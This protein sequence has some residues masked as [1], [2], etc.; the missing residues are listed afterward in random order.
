M[1]KISPVQCL[2]YAT[3]Y[4]E[5]L[6][7]VSSD[8]GVVDH[9]LFHAALDEDQPGLADAV[10]EILYSPEDKQSVLALEDDAAQSVLDIIQHAVD[11]ELLRT[12]DAN[13]RAC[14][15]VGKL[16]KA[17]DKVPSSILIYGVTQREEHASFCGGFGDVF[18][19]MY[20]GS[21][22]ALKHMRMFQE[23]D[24]RHIRRKFAREAMVWQRLRDPY[25]VPLIGIDT[26]SFPSSLCL[27]SPWMAHGTV[28]KYL[29]GI[30]RAD[31]QRT[32]D[33]LIHEIAQGLAFLHN[34]KVVHGDLRGSNI[35]V[36]DVGRAC[37][38]DFGLTILTDATVT[39][40]PNAAGSV[41]WMAPETLDPRAW[42]LTDARRTPASDIYAFGCVCLEL[43]TGLPPFHRENFLDAPVMLQVLR[44]ERPSRPAG[45]VIPDHIWKIMQ[46]CWAHNIPDRPTILGIVLQLTRRR[47]VIE[48]AERGLR[49][50]RT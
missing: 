50:Q 49:Q 8:L 20:R 41:R 43:Y 34:Q 28:L 19:A 45:E 31:R 14:R 38:T 7:A 33:R 16:A 46:Q 35:L 9:H 11:S 5:T 32:V 47:E 13:S 37:L 10:E 1:A 18:K 12:C 3:R 39:Q 15:L 42:G 6:T 44:G 4:R 27:V 25:I 23:T 48:L 2:I 17:C 24:Q 30:R 22:V 26:E 21:P 36:N 40:T 29:T